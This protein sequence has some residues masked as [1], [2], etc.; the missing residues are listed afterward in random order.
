MTA[1]SGL[2]LERF[3]YRHL[4]EDF[5]KRAL[6]AVFTAYRVS[7]DECA[8]GFA[9]TEARNVQPYYKRGKLEGYLRDVAAMFPGVTTEVIRADQSGWFHTEVRS[10][11][12]VLTENSV[13]T[14]CALME[15]A[16]F[17]LTLARS[18]QG[19]LFEDERLTEGPA[20]YVLLLHSRS[21]WQEPESY[22]KYRHLPGS[23]YIAFPSPTLDH[24]I[25]EINLFAKFPG[26]VEAHLPQEWDQDAR[27]RYR[28]NSR[29][30]IA[31]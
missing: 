4:S 11:P 3:T 21:V 24:Y 26:V 9:E 22:R 18:S 15:K 5:W 27:L 7:W 19:V 12:V 17:R 23:A 14:P 10:G 29:R 30:R 25:H 31:I 28:D 8:S 16:E 13:P 2:E 1:M 6:Q 20:L